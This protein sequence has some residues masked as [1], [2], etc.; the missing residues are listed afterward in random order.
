MLNCGFPNE[1]VSR[2]SMKQTK[3]AM[4]SAQEWHA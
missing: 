4:H 3:V 2:R 1:A